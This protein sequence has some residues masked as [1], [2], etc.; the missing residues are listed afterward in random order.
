MAQ[1]V[2]SHYLT[3]KRFD[4]RETSLVRR[5]AQFRDE[6]GSCVA[7]VQCDESVKQSRF[8]SLLAASSMSSRE[9]GG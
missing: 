8:F 9:D 1:L 6:R 7:K 2:A 5:H 3:D 4:V